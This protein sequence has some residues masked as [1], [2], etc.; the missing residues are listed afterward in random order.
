[1]ISTNSGESTEILL[2]T[3]GVEEP[4]LS[5]SLKRQVT[6]GKPTNVAVV[7]EYLAVLAWACKLPY[8]V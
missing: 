4:A 1:M 6:F 7:V 8:K 5:I 2:E 3:H